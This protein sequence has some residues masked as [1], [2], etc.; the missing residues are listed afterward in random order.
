MEVGT[1][2][3]NFLLTQKNKIIKRIF[4]ILSVYLFITAN[5]LNGWTKFDG[6]FF[7]R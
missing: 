4:K 2:K 1:S 7:S 5:F 6:V 3:K